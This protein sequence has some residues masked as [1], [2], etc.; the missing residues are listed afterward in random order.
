MMKCYKIMTES[1]QT[2]FPVRLTWTKVGLTQ[3]VTIPALI[4]YPVCRKW[5]TTGTQHY[6]DW[7]SL[8]TA[9]TATGFP[10]LHCFCF[11]DVNH[12]CLQNKYNLLYVSVQP[13]SDR[14]IE[15]WPTGANIGHVQVSSNYASLL[16]C[17]WW[18]L[19]KKQ[20]NKNWPWIESDNNGLVLWFMLTLNSETK[21]RCMI[22]T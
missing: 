1:Y 14:L 22:R 12:M 2:T 18:P 16:H 5:I 13:F 3:T 7:L 17:G 4:D 8:A 20:T 15:H 11:T 19:I 21:I 10:L 9:V 6:S